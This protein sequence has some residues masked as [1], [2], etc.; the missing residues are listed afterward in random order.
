V[1]YV[2]RLDLVQIVKVFVQVTEL[3]VPRLKQGQ[4]LKRPEDL[5]LVQRLVLQLRAHKLR[6]HRAQRD[7]VRKGLLVHLADHQNLEVLD[8]HLLVREEAQVDRVRAQAVEV[9]LAHHWSL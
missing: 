5:R 8:H 6:L 3:K 7:P 9:N 1:E 4:I 2:R